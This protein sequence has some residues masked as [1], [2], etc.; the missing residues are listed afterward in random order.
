[1]TCALGLFSSHV[2]IYYRLVNRPVT[3]RA[4]LSYNY[5]NH[6]HCMN[7]KLHLDDEAETKRKGKKGENKNKLSDLRSREKPLSFKSEIER[8]KV[9]K[10]AVAREEE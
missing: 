10:M 7:L 9:R 1:M 4:D 5:H 6:H 8:K 3:R 2:A